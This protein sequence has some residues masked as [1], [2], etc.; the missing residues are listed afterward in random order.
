M[1]NE[2]QVSFGFLSAKSQ[3][4]IRTASFLQRFAVSEY[5]LCM[6][7]VNDARRQLCS[8]LCKLETIFGPRASCAV[9]FLLS[10]LMGHSCCWLIMCAALCVAVPSIFDVCVILRLRCAWFVCIRAFQFA[11]RIDS[12]RFVMRIDSNIVYSFS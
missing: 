5:S 10:S 7:F 11:I 2:C 3:I 12:I 1:V 6:L 8:V 9:L 4:L